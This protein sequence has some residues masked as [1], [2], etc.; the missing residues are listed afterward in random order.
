MTNYRFEFD[1]EAKTVEVIE[2]T[3]TFDDR[4]VPYIHRN[5][6]AEYEYISGEGQFGLKK[7]SGSVPPEVSQT[8]WAALHAWHDISRGFLWKST[9]D[10][11]L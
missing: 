2:V 6:L 3:E 8:L 7:I 10:S 4:V 9:F 5:S 11:R 1:H